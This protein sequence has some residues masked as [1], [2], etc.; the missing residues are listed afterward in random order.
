M[1]EKIFIISATFTVFMIGFE[2]CLTWL[3]AALL[4]IPKVS[5]LRSFRFVILELLIP[6]PVALVIGYA[7]SCVVG[8]TLGIQLGLFVGMAFLLYLFL[9]IASSIFEIDFIYAS[10]LSFFFI[11]ANLFVAFAVSTS[12]T[13]GKLY[14]TIISIPK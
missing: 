6:V 9:E 14:E 1:M 7:L 8:G 5:I 11:I 12:P 3:C 13:A 2:A 4:Q 10:L